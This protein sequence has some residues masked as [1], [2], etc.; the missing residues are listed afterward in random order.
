MV[1]LVGIVAILVLV[2][3]MF[4]YVMSYE[5]VMTLIDT[6]LTIPGV[7]AGLIAMCKAQY[8]WMSYFVIAM[9]LLWIIVSS[10]RRQR[11]DRRY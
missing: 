6:A 2:A 4:A 8:Y 9:L 5:M 1:V 3:L 11:D 10:V 7:D